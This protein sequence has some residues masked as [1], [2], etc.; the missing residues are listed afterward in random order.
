MALPP[1]TERATY[2]A[3]SESVGGGKL[4]PFPAGETEEMLR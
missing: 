1:A 4:P 3:M 2:T